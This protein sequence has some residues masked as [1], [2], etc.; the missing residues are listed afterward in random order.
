VHIDAIDTFRLRIDT[1]GGGVDARLCAAGAEFQDG[2]SVPQQ[3]VGLA[4]ESDE[5][6]FRAFVEAKDCTVAETDNDTRA[7]MGPEPISRKYGNVD[8]SGLGLGFRRSLQRDVS[9]DVV[10]I[11]V[12]VRIFLSEA[13]DWQSGEPYQR[14]NTENRCFPHHFPI[15]L[16]M[17]G[18]PTRP[19]ISHAISIP[20]SRPR[21]QM[22]ERVGNKEVA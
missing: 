19:I 15:L 14:T 20:R 5:V 17:N 18:R 13:R 3:D 10:D 11:G 2:A 4:I 22:I 21:G 1:S 16:I 8:G 12:L 9:V 7:R 6:D